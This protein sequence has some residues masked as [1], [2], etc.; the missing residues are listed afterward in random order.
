[1]ASDSTTKAVSPMSTLRT[2]LRS[3]TRRATVALIAGAGI[4]AA[5]LS[6]PSP[7]GADTPPSAAHGAAVAGQVLRMLNTER[8][9]FHLPAL[10]MNSHLVASAHG[11]N[12][13]MAAWNVMAHQ[14]PGELSLGGRIGRTGYP[15]HYAGENVGWNTNWTLAGAY[16]LETMMFNELP[17][18]DD[19]RLNILGSA[20]RD[21]GI[22]IY[23]DTAHHKL[24][25]TEDFGRTF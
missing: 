9:L 5:V 20:Y 25:L 4:T 12:L 13:H 11:H 22:D 1:M 10:R 21:I 8:A 19:H 17:P 3:R 14:L 7:A 15:W 2:A 18:N 16:L 24:W 23:Y 6:A